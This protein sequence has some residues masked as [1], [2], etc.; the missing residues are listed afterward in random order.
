[1]FAIDAMKVQ[2]QMRE[3]MTTSV[4]GRKRVNCMLGTF[5]YFLP[6]ADFSSKIVQECYQSYKQFL[7]PTCLDRF[8]KSAGQKSPI[9]G[10]ELM[11]SLKTD[12]EWKLS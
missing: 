11:Y 12:K 8:I 7:G 10:K 1:M 3:Q 9:V 2:K 6:S 4:Y 5:A